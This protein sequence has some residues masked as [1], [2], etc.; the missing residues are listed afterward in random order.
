MSLD[1]YLAGPNGESDW[2]PRD[3][4]VDFIAL[5]AQFDTLVMGRHTY[6]IARD[7]LGAFGRAKIF[8]VS[9]SLRQAENSGV[10]VIP[11]LTKEGVAAIRAQSRKDV[12]LFGGGNLFRTL[13][14]MGEVDAVEVTVAP[15]LLGGGIPLLPPPSERA[16]LRLASNRIY[17]SGLVT[18][19]YEV[20][21]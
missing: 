21:R 2:I 20:Q 4:V 18:L 1:G 14:K 16:I 11:E 15:V 19:N 12:W 6:A 3:P 17:K 5:F 7:Q 8:V 13:L 9:R 10:T